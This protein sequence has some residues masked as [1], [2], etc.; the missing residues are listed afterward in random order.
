MSVDWFD[1]CVRLGRTCARPHYEMEGSVENIL[2]ALDRFSI[3]EALVYHASG[4]ETHPAVG[5]RLLLEAT[6]D[7]PRLHPCLTILPPATEEFPPPQ[8]H[9]PQLIEQGVR[10][11]RMSPASHNYSFATATCGELFEVLAEMHMPLFIDIGTFADWAAIDDVAGDFP[12]LRLV[13]VSFGYGHTR[14]AYPVLRRR[15]HIYLEIHTY[16]LH[17]GLE[18]FIPRF[19]AGKLLFG[20]GMPVFTPA[21]TMTMLACASI[22][23][24]DKQLIARDNLVGLLEGCNQHATT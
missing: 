10:A 19:G 1:A 7:E 15:E 20:S 24:A 17:N 23:P 16:E 12:Q 9:L 5:N 4:D 2:A 8:Q 18:H 21:S 11:V 22:S 3:A 13:L 6:A 14:Q